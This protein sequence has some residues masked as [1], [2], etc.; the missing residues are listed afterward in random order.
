MVGEDGHRGWAYYVAVDPDAQGRG[1]GRAIM[2][3]AEAWL[4]AR[5]VWKFQVM[6]RRDN[7]AVQDFYA[8]LGFAPSDVVVMQKVIE[9]G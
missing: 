5:G 7:V 1:F 6:I 9:P 2:A 4:R 3:A 8:G